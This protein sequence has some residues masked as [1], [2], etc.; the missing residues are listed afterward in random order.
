MY[1]DAG[2]EVVRHLAADPLAVLPIV[3]RRLRENDAEWRK[4]RNEMTLGWRR[5]MDLNYEGVMDVT[6]HFYKN[7]VFFVKL[8]RKQPPPKPL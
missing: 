5:I 7:E 3:F 4:V 2:D 6:C 1:G 8:F